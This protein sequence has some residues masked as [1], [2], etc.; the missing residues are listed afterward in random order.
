[1]ETLVRAV[2][3]GF[4]LLNLLSRDDDDEADAHV[5]GAE[6][7][8]L[9]NVAKVLKVLEQRG[10]GPAGQV[11]DSS[12]SAREDAGKILCDSAPGDMRHAADDAC[13]GQLFDDGKVAAM[14]AHEGGAGLILELVDILIWAVLCDFK[15][16]FAGEGVAVRV[17]AVG[18]QADENVADLDRFTRNDVG[19]VDAA[20]DGPGE[21]V[22]AVSVKAGHLRGLA[23]NEG[24]AICAASFGE[25][26]DY[27]LDGF[28]VLFAEFA[29][30][31]IVE[32][33]ERCGA[34]HGDVVDAM[35]DQIRA[36]C[37]MDTELEGYFEL[38]A[39]AVC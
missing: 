21:V 14:G 19:A 23:A 27:S 26:A 37:V 10:N 8:V 38:G 32:E 2:E 20:D 17:Q 13:S 25:A 36:N 4:G 16:Q 15:E 7:L 11:D 18:G 33:E 22:F 24:A 34:L 29:G 28:R 12:H 5:E 1:M 9:L 30:G 3:N 39:D 6:H 35:I 31:E